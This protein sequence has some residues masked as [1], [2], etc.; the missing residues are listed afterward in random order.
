MNTHRET[1][2][3]SFYHRLGKVETSG[4]A[5]LV[6]GLIATTCSLVSSAGAF[7]AYRTVDTPFL[8]L[9]ILMITLVPFFFILASSFLLLRGFQIL[10]R[11][12]KKLSEEVERDNLTRLANR[13]GFVRHGRNM[14]VQAGLQK[15]PLSLILLDADHFKNI[16]DS[17]GHLAGDLALQHLAKILRQACR[18][19][20]LVARWGGEEFAILLRAAD[21]S[22]A[23]GFAERLRERIAESPFSWNGKQVELTMSAGVTEWQHND[24]DL[25]NMIIRADEALYVA[26][27]KGRNQVQVSHQQIDQVEGFELDVEFCDA[28][29]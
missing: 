24:D 10:E 6:S 22:G 8:S 18:E 29:A 11:N 15:A 28:A 23:H 14:L 19:S 17:H 9:A 2:L 5:L 26:K 12:N 21:L 16:N 20:D 1:I 7:W 25:H 3:E 27:S 13:Y 4:Q